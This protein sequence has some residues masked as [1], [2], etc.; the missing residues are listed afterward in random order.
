MN[1]VYHYAW[2]VY[3]YDGY[4]IDCGNSSGWEVWGNLVFTMIILKKKV[5]ENWFS[6]VQH[7]IDGR[8]VIL[9]CHK[10]S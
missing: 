2:P 6:S 10:H 4:D 3:T 9:A 8:F 7:R 1:E 5:I